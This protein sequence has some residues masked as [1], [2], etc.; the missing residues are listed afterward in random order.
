MRIRIDEKD[1]INYPFLKESQNFVSSYAGS[2]ERFLDTSTG[3]AAL[4][5]AK[6]RIL[7]A[8]AGW[9]PC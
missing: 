1:F 6:E 2:P 7:A 5:Q 9:F 3:K 8:I 4:S